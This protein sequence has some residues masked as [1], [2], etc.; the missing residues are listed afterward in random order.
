MKHLIII[1]SSK[2]RFLDPIALIVLGVGITTALFGPTRTHAQGQQAFRLSS[3]SF[4]V[5]NAEKES[6]EP[7]EKAAAPEKL[8]AEP[9]QN[10]PDPLDEPYMPPASAEGMN[11][12]FGG[13]GK[14]GWNN[15]TYIAAAR[16]LL[17]V[18]LA[19]S[20]SGKSFALIQTKAGE[21][22]MLVGEGVEIPLSI[23]G[24]DGSATVKAITD[25]A[26]I[27]VL[28]NGDEITIR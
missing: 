19:K 8:E 5:D 15:L 17:I 2:R 27:L 21:R 18:G 24:T 20:S 10:K 7:A 6:V 9:L 13:N 25:Q 22:A 23:K 26:I 4:T 1:G 28:A 3:N 12:P 11:D 14:A 16:E